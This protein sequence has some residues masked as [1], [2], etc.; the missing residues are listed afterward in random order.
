L[1]VF[2]TWVPFVFLRPYFVHLGD[3]GLGYHGR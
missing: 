2:N 3:V 1:A